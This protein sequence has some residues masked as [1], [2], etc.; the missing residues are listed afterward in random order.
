MTVTKMKGKK[1][2]KVLRGGGGGGLEP[3]VLA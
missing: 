1:R 2:M 3:L